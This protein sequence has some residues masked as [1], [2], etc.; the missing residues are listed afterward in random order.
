MWSQR[1][2]ADLAGI[3][4]YI[5]QFAPLAAQRFAARLI[6]A[7]DSL[8]D[9]P[10]RGRTLGNRRRE[11]VAIPPYLIRYRVTDSTIE[12]LTIRHGAQR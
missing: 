10:L 3:R 1:A 11:L 4:D 9:H 7:A 6:M 2:Q 12:I 5:G 8:A